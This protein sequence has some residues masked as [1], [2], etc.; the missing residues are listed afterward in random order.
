MKSDAM[1][2]TYKRR[3]ACLA[4]NLEPKFYEKCCSYLSISIFT[5]P[6]SHIQTYAQIYRFALIECIYFLVNNQNTNPVHLNQS[7]QH[8]E[9]VKLH[10][11]AEEFQSKNS[12]QG[13][14][15]NH[16]DS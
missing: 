9:F 1:L 11:L 5:V 16:V 4:R 8:C 3:C 6:I 10:M 15:I 14:S 12:R 7:L 2:A 13:A